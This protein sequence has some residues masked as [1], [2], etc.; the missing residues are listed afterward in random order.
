MTTTAHPWRGLLS[1]VVAGL[2][3]VVAGLAGLAVLPVL[4]GLPGY[5]TLAVPGY[6]PTVVVAG[7]VAVVLAV[8]LRR[9]MGRV[10]TV[11]AVAAGVATAALAVVVAIVVATTISAGGSVNPLTAIAPTSGFAPPDGDPVYATG[12]DG[13]PLHAAVWNP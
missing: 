3:L 9:R 5:A 13:V 6:G 10:A 7:L 8:L 11:V 12:P 1:G 4:G 2:L